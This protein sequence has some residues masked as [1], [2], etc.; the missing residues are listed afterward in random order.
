MQKKL[1]IVSIAMLLLIL[2]ACGSSKDKES[3]QESE[4]KEPK[5]LEEV[6]VSEDE[7]VPEDEVIL[8]I[9]GEEIKGEQY[10]R[11]YKN[12]KII[13]SANQD[14][15][16]LEDVKSDTIETLIYQTVLAQDAKSKGIEVTDE[17]FDEEF[18]F[19]QE[20]NSEGLETLLEQFQMTEESFKD[21]LR[22][23]ILY[24]KY[25]EEEFSDVEVDDEEVEAVY[26]ELKE[27]EDDLPPLKDVH[28]N[29]KGQ[30]K[31]QKVDDLL[32]KRIDE[33]IEEFTIEQ[34]I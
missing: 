32:T 22:Y 13:K 30:L 27:G 18:N 29:I 4:P 26:D 7:I 6:E 28:E 33:L 16:S 5:E 11:L 2:A 21:E 14:L 25:T 23:N 24:Q 34:H 19:I 1:M 31:V 17:E 9:E 8:E 15:N 20:E 10:N 12:T 3:E